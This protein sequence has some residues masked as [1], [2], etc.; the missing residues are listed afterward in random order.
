MTNFIKREAAAIGATAALMFALLMITVGY[1][2]ALV[3]TTLDPGN[4]GADVSE[5][6]AFLKL[7]AAVYPEGLVTGFYGPL[8]TAAVQ[9]FQC[10][11]AIVCSGS[12]ATTGYGRVGPITLAKVQSL[13]G[14][15]S[16]P[17]TGFPPAGAGDDISA[18]ILSAP[19]VTITSTSAVI[20]WTTSEMARSRVMY[21]TVAPTLSPA[22]LATMPSVA[23]A[24]FDTSSD[25]TLTGLSPN[26]TYYYVLESVDASGNLQWGIGYSFRTSV[27]G[28]TS[29]V[30]ST[31]S[32]TSGGTSGGTSSG[33]TGTTGTGGTGY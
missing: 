9:R 15:V 1:A 28:S 18:P 11:Y 26:T 5:L 27:A 2:S 21:S 20:H 30:A 25:V 19:T 24:S 7:D 32:G 12:V 13:Q 23:D 33:T 4:S 29:A 17:P 16:L 6:Q 14:G 22:A 8:T 10:K 3:A 31:P